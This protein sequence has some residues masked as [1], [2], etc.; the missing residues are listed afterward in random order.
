MKIQ[1]PGKIRCIHW[2]LQGKFHARRGIFMRI[3]EHPMKYSSCA[4][5]GSNTQIRLRP[6]E[7][8]SLFHRLCLPVSQVASTKVMGV[9]TRITT[10][11]KAGEYTVVVK[12]CTFEF[13]G[14]R[15]FTIAEK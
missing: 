13:P 3:K 2:V 10:P 12:Q 15:T 11:G 6:G 1:E 7:E 8:Y 14:K 5:R 9:G 4:T